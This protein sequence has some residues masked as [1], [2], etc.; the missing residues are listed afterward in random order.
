MLASCGCCSGQTFDLS[1]GSAF[2]NEFEGL[3]KVSQTTSGTR[4]EVPRSLPS[5][6][7]WRTGS[8]FNQFVKSPISVSWQQA[9][10]REHLK[11]FSQTQRIAIVLDRR[12]NPDQ[13]LDLVVRN[14]S[15][16]QFLLRTAQQCGCKFC[17]LGDGYYF[18]PGENAER[19]LAINAILRRPPKKTQPPWSVVESSAWD[20]LATPQEI[21]E[22]W[23]P[24]S[25]FEISGLDQV[26]HDLMAESDAGE[27]RLDLRLALL[28]SQFDLWFRQNKSGDAI[29]IVRPPKT[30]TATLIID[31]YEINKAL[32]ER[33]RAVAPTCKVKKIRRSL[34][35][36]GPAQELEMARNVMIESYRPKLRKL[37]E[38]RFQLNVRNHRRQ[39]LDAVAKQ[40][41]MD[42]VIDPKCE[43][44]LNDVVSVEVK[45]ATVNDLLDAILFGARCQHS[46]VGQTLQI[47]P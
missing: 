20:R 4:R 23:L 29:A 34:S 35:I 24:K 46:I 13:I 5:G 45:D 37:E 32:L 40:L 31:G 9:K 26:D 18:G 27:L 43:T 28:L 22:R 12:I 42:L 38:K 44:M 47:A 41:A 14:V 7:Q 10:L 3:G 8:D 1:D 6:L 25:D 33:V 30:M 36:S 11:Q 17:R 21:I 39:I 2:A 16:E 15:V 19:L